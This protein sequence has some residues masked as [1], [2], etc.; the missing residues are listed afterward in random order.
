MSQ[1]IIVNNPWP[2][3]GFSPLGQDEPLLNRVA[4]TYYPGETPLW[5]CK[6]FDDLCTAAQREILAGVPFEA[7]NLYNVIEAVAGCTGAVLWYGDDYTMLDECRSG[8]RLKTLVTR[9]LT[10]P[11]CEIYCYYT[12]MKRL[13]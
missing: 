5:I 3:D 9:G 8:E 6:D 10:L 1:F 13:L 2:P 4:D 11:S 12:T 7:T